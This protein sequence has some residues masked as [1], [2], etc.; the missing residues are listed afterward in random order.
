MDP[1]DDEALSMLTSVGD[2]LRDCE[3]PSAVAR[4]AVDGLR[5]H[6]DAEAAALATGGDLAATAGPVPSGD[7]LPPVSQ[8][9]TVAVAAGEADRAAVAPVADR[10]TLWLWTADEPAPAVAAVA[11]DRVG[12]AL[13]RAAAVRDHEY[14]A[15]RIET[16][17]SVVNHDLSNPLTIADGY[18][19][20]VARDVDSEHLSAVEAAIDR[21]DDV[22]TAAVTLARAGRPVDDPVPVPVASL[23][24]EAWR[25]VGDDAATLSVVDGALAA[26]P[27]RLL[28]LFE[29]LFENAVV[30][31]DADRVRVGAT[32]RGLVVADDG[33]GI[34]PDRRDRATDAGYSTADGRPGLGLCVAGWLARAHGW[35]LALEESDAGGLAVV[36]A[37][38]VTEPSG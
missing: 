21:I 25:A 33:C 8:P 34:D 35:S 24:R 3:S 23:A 11:G 36:L 18:L 20:V 31:G 37:G 16:V 30:H 4:T 5:E 28:E 38:A 7:D 17:A 2:D 22:A 27:E 19:E 26:D 1:G 12:A 14:A 32:E 6:L 10:G 15:E 13:A 29:R 9:T